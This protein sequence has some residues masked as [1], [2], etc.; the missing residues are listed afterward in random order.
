MI[1]EYETIQKSKLFYHQL[2]ENSYNNIL[3]CTNLKVQRDELDM[4]EKIE[5]FSLRGIYLVFIN[6]EDVEYYGT[7]ILMGYNTNNKVIEEVLIPVSKRYNLSKDIIDFLENNIQHKYINGFRNN[8]TKLLRRLYT[9]AGN[10][11]IEN[12]IYGYLK[13]K[14]YEN[15]IEHLLGTLGEKKCI[16]YEN[17]LYRKN[18]RRLKAKLDN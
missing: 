18:R 4:V 7:E 6:V 3:S 5:R 17:S 9:L 14:S 8:L 10:Y 16:A 12:D 15:D 13:A 11:L 2:K 1:Q